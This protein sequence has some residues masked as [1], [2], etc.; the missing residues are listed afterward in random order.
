MLA[1]ATSGTRA[2][3]SIVTW[4]DQRSFSVAVEKPAFE[5]GEHPAGQPAEGLPVQV[6]GE[7]LGRT[8]RAIFTAHPEAL[9]VMGA[10]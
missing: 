7:S 9:M 5:A 6:D 1:A 8:T 4:H 2:G 3:S 10:V